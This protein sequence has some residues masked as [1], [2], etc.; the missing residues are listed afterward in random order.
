[1]DGATRPEP[2]I[3]NSTYLQHHAS[4]SSTAEQQAAN[5]PAVGR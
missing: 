3:L 1:M 5:Q 2:S 4:P